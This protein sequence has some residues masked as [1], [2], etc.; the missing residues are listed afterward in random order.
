MEIEK[1]YSTH[2]T[3]EDRLDLNSFLA[4]DRHRLEAIRYSALVT[5]KLFLFQ[6]ICLCFSNPRI[7]LLPFV[8]FINSIVSLPGKTGNPFL[9]I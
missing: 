2:E 8:L 1:A 6:F 9:G 4:R 3:K 5:Q 7:I